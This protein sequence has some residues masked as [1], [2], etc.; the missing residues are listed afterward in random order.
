MKLALAAAALA[1]VAGCGPSSVGSQT[2]AVGGHPDVTGTVFTI[3][4]ENENA[5][6]IIQPQNPTFYSLAQSNARATAYTSSTHPSLPNYIMLTSGSTN[7]VTTDNDPTSNVPVPGTANIADQLDAAGVKWRAYMEGMGEPCKLDSSGDYSAHHDPFLYYTS[8]V[9]DPARC[10]DR[11]V[12]F[13]QSF[14]PDLDS[15]A[16]RYM[17][18]TPNMCDDMHNCSAGAA[19]AWLG[20]VI[21]R[22]T[23]SQA[24]KN[25]GAIFVLFDEGSSRAP[26]ASATLPTIVASPRLVS[27]GYVSAT[28]YDHRSYLATVED[29][30][31]LP[32][33]P[34]T[35][36]ATSMDD[37][38]VTK[39]APS[40]SPG[41]VA[42]PAQPA[43]A[44]TARWM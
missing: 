9:G 31:D 32:R 44:P 1:A 36:D 38:F 10:H 29:I 20:R 26:G 3:V 21:R 37:F 16:Y 8:M 6:D 13:D 40:A 18:I 30:L 34:S 41:A 14:G 7:G 2:I 43:P 35:V 11:I 23:A 24:Y 15:G 12:D 17:W 5:A 22:I 28:P 27:A 25:G 42:A 4:F 39:G 19:D 33:L